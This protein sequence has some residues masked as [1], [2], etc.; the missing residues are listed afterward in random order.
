MGEWMYRSTFS[1]PRHSL[2]VSG[3]LHVPAALPPGKKPPVPVGQVAGWG[4]APVWTTWRRENSWLYRDS[5]SDPSVFQP[6]AS[7]YTEFSIPAP[8]QSGKKYNFITEKPMAFWGGKYCLVY[9]W[10]YTFRLVIGLID[11][12]EIVTTSNCSAIANS[13]SPQF[14]RAPNK[15]N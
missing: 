2:E 11:H 7:R 6:V 4:P 5:N 13:Q 8:Y 12:S 9:E 10:I 1:W 14:T 15:S 3:Q